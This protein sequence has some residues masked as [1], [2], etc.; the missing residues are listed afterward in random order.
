MKRLRWI[1]I[2]DLCGKIALPRLAYC[3]D[4]DAVKGPPENWVGLRDY[5]LCKTCVESLTKPNSKEGQP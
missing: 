3:G 5:I 2:C 1:Y 4:G